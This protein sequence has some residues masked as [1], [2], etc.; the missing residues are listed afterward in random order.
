[1]DEMLEWKK[2]KRASRPPLSL[3]LFSHFIASR[4]RAASA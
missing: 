1:M 4:K 3:F 2:K